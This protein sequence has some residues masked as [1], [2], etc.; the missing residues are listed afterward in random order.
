MYEKGLLWK[1]ISSEV[2]GFKI[3]L[4]KGDGLHLPLILAEVGN[5]TSSGEC[6]LSL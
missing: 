5:V 1:S 6:H 3:V 2:C 4:N